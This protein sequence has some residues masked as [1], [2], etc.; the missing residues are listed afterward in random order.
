LYAFCIR[1]L[2]EAHF[3]HDPN[4]VD[5]ALSILSHLRETWALL[6]QQLAEERADA[7]SG[8]AEETA[9]DDSLALRTA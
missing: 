5:E 3:R 8:F 7:E 4:L 2:N 9:Y 6:L 1:K